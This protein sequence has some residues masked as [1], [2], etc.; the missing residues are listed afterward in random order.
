M[1]NIEIV[2]ERLEYTQTAT[3]G[4]M[5]I[6]NKEF[7]TLEPTYTSTGAVQKGMAIP[8]GSYRA[9]IRQT[10]KRK[11]HL[12]ILNVEGRTNILVHTGNSHSDTRGCILVGKKRNGS[13]IFC[14]R[15]ALDEILKEIG[16]KNIIITI[17]NT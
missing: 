5:C 13:F 9:I 7:Y 1:E 11:R 8:E 3:F 17:K 12:Y 14:S 16:D 2:I 10:E 6:N 4:K 15:K